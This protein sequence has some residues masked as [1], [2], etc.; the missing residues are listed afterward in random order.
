LDSYEILMLKYTYSTKRL[1]AKTRASLVKNS[2]Q[3]LLNDDILT[4]CH[5]YS[6]TSHLNY[7]SP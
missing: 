5:V 3:S 2:P 7:T 4:L 1:P 6:I